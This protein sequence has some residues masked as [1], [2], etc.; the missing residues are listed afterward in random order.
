MTMN[1]PIILVTLIT[2]EKVLAE[3]RLNDWSEKTEDFTRELMWDIN[4]YIYNGTMWGTHLCEVIYPPNIFIN[5]THIVKIELEPEFNRLQAILKGE[6]TS[7][8]WINEKMELL[9]DNNNK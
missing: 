1:N 7:E 4:N 9:A 3:I 8:D 2:G 6:Q 5:R